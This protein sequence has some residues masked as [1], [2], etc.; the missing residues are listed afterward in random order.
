METYFQL[1]NE[2][3]SSGYHFKLA[4]SLAQN[5]KG[6][7]DLIKSNDVTLLVEMG[8]CSEAK[9]IALDRLTTLENIEIVY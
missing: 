3:D 2:L 5:N 1:L 9:I 7:Q 8:E 6:L 4:I